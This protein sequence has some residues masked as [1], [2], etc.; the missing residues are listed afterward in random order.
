[1]LF[2]RR[3]KNSIKIAN[4]E[5]KEWKYATCGYCSTGCSIEVGLNKE[6]KP[7]SSRGVGNADVNRGKL[8]LKGIFEHEIFDSPGRGTEPK[9]RDN[10]LNE[11]KITDWDTALDKTYSDIRRTQERHGRDSVAII[12]TG[13]MLTEEFYPKRYPNR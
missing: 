9:L 12:S 6:G 8:C 11:W 2:G 4:K 10:F 7:V 13:Q 1:M 3:K 5:I